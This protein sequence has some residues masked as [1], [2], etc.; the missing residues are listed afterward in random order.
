MFAAKAQ[1]LIALLDEMH[2]ISS[3]AQ[4]IARPLRI[5]VSAQLFSGIDEG[6]AR[7]VLDLGDAMQLSEGDCVSCVEAVR[8]GTVDGALVCSMK[9]SYPECDAL[10]LF[11]VPAY[12]WMRESSSLAGCDEVALSDLAQK[13]LLFLS[14]DPS[15]YEGLLNA[16]HGA[17]LYRMDLRTVLSTN[18]AVELIRRSDCIGVVSKH[19]ARHAPEG[20]VAVPLAGN[21]ADWRFFFLYSNS[22]KA[23]RRALS[24]VKEAKRKASGG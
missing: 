8:D 1:Q 23:S 10:H 13:S 14:D 6:F 2:R 15:Q 20:T 12:A 4:E 7:S 11:T 9:D 16:F 3:D 24:L 18:L 17:G 22:S 19:F 5:K 21:S